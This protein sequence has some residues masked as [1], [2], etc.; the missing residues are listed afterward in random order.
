ME[1]RVS[2]SNEVF[3]DELKSE[4]KPIIGQTVYGV[5]VDGKEIYRMKVTRLGKISLFPKAF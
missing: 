1:G 4:I 2:V 5:C 3:A